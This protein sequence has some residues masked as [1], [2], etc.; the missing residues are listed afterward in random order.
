VHNSQPTL[1]PAQRDAL[2]AAIRDAG[3]CLVAFSGG[4]D[5]ALVLRV[6]VQVLGRDNVLAVTGRSP[7]VAARELDDAK[8][9][10]DLIGV[11]HVI[12]D[13]NEFSDPNYLANPTNRCYYCKTEL[14][15][16]LSPLARE[17]GFTTILNGANA[18]D[19]GDHRPGMIAAT[20]FNVRSPLADAGLTKADVRALSAEFGLPTA[21]KPAAPCLS[22]RL[23]YGEAV[24]PEKLSMIERAE[25]VLRDLGFPEC[26]VRH[27][28]KL[29]RIEI[30]EP[31]I[32]ALL[33]ADTRAAIDAAF[34]E[35]GYTWVAIDIR[36]LRSGSLNE[37][38][39]FGK[40]QPAL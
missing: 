27:H 10:A 14:Y 29:A 13:T 23:P 19:L 9:I 16:R 6:A 1:S 12:L 39:A 37:V 33:A 31:R 22:S 25:T 35:I 32:A 8:R 11:E 17:R 18:D 36:G 34:R 24:T 7:S 30:P 26:R 28:D 3:R 21:D 15:G 2:F 40:V 20:E 4:V 5:S 38:I